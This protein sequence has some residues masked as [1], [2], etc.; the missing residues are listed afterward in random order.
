MKPQDVE[1]LKLYIIENTKSAQDEFGHM[2]GS[3][4]FQI[5]EEQIEELKKGKQIA[6]SD[7]EY[8]NFISLVEPV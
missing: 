8:S 4:W 3:G 7:G 5:T 1:D 2:W 6:F